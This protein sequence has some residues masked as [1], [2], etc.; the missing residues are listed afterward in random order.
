[1]KFKQSKLFLNLIKLKSYFEEIKIIFKIHFSDGQIR[2]FHRSNR[3][4]GFSFCAWNVTGVLWIHHPRSFFSAPRMEN[5][6]FCHLPQRRRTRLFRQ[7]ALH[8][9]V[10]SG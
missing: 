5:L 4:N 3:G 8:I 1:M 2:N 7:T 10:I 9:M 6:R